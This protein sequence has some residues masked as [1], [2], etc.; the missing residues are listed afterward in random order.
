MDVTDDLA[1]GWV[2]AYELWGLPLGRQECVQCLAVLGGVAVRAGDVDVLAYL[3]FRGK[4]D[5]ST[6]G[7]YS[8]T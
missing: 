3:S 8:A 5:E 1:D 2:V 4:P 6:C 7:P